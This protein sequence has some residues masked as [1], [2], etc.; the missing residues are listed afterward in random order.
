MLL[1]VICE[2][3]YVVLFVHLVLFCGLIMLLGCT[4]EFSYVV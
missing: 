1:D 2:L 4:C 3:S